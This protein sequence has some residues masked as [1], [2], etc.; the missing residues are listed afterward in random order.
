VIWTG[1]NYSQQSPEWTHVSG[2]QPAMGCSNSIN[3]CNLPMQ[4]QAAH[5]ATRQLLLAAL[6]AT[7]MRGVADISSK[8]AA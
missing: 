2:F 6:P 7:A 1:N 5:M 3:P 4:W 8:A